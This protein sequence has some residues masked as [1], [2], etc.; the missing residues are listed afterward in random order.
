MLVLASPAVELAA[1]DTVVS[2]GVVVAVADSPTVDTPTVVSLV[3]GIV[4][5]PPD[6]VLV[7]A[8]E[9][10]EPLVVPSETGLKTQEA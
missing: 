2:S 7:P 9:E 5:D 6:E 10:L 4:E 3:L 8:P 1:V